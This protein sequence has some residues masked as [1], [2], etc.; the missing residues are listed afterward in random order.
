MFEPRGKVKD[1][2]LAGL[3]SNEGDETN[4]IVYDKGSSYLRFDGIVIRNDCGKFLSG[5][6][7]VFM[8]QGTETA[9]VSVQGVRIEN[10]SAITI[11]GVEGRQKIHV[12]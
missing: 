11:T 6:D 10:N 9:T 2:I 4:P 7:V 12:M 3:S 5:V 8:W 1:A